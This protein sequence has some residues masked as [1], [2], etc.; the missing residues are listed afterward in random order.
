MPENSER[1]PLEPELEPRARDERSSLLLTE[2][3]PRHVWT[4][5]A[6]L[7]VTYILMLHVPKPEWLIRLFVPWDNWLDMWIFARALELG[8][9]VCAAM[10]LMRWRRLGL[11]AIGLD[12]RHWLN[13]LQ[14]GVVGG[15]VGWAALLTALLLLTRSHYSL[16]WRSASQSAQP[17]TSL[18]GSMAAEGVG[19]TLLFFVIGACLEELFVRGLLYTRVRRLV[20]SW[21]LA[22]VICACAFAYGHHTAGLPYAGSQFVYSLVMGGLFVHSRSLLVVVFAHFVTNTL[23]LVLW[24]CGVSFA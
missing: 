17:G 10:V 11:E 14:W 19:R 16:S 9:V 24:A 1:K 18:V 12:L 20:G 7:G 13:Q 22:N 6:C 4:D 15:L 23:Q 21:G 5:C 8:L 2:L 3:T